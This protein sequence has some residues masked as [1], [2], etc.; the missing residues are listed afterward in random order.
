MGL[1]KWLSRVGATGGLVRSFAD[2]YKQIR[3]ANPD[4]SR[5]SDKDIFRQMVDARMSILPNPVHR[6]IIEL[7]LARP[8][9]GLRHLLRGIVTVENGFMEPSSVP[10]SLFE[11]IDEELAKSGLP[12]SVVNG[13]LC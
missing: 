2:G 8:T 1:F 7:Y 4:H 9:S 11:V 5:L 3:A 13:K 10:A 6:A 12:E